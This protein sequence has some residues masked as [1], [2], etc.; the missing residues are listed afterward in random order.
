MCV[1]QTDK[2]RGTDKKQVVYVL[3]EARVP[4][5]A[6]QFFYESDMLNEFL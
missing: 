4:L 5:A 1:N 3:R 2:T 6:A